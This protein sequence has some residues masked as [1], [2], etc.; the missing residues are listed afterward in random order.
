MD[1][2]DNSTVSLNA[3][4][5]KQV[6]QALSSHIDACHVKARG[7]RTQINAAETEAELDLITVV[8]LSF[9]SIAL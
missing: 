2:A 7:L 1:F 6:G 4:E 9:S 5:L 3:T 8:T